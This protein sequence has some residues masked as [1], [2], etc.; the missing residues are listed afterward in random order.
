[1]FLQAAVIEV[2]LYKVFNFAGTALVIYIDFSRHKKA[3]GLQQPMLGYSAPAAN[4][5]EKFDYHQIL[6]GTKILLPALIN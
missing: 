6:S 1:M 5:I 3:V 4:A 2:D